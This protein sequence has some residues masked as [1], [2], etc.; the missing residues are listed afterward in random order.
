MLKEKTFKASKASINYAEGP[1]SGPPLILLHGLSGRWQS[2]L[3]I[4]QPLTLRWHVFALDLRGHGKSSH[5]GLY[6]FRDYADDIIEFARELTSE[7]AV[8]IGQSLGALIAFVVTSE[9]PESIRAVVDLDAEPNPS[10]EW[11]GKQSEAMRDLMI[12]RK[13]LAQNNRTVEDYI[14]ALADATRPGQDPPVRIGDTVDDIGL[15]IGAFYA[16]KLDPEVYTPFIDISKDWEEFFEDYDAQ[17]ILPKI[18]C[19]VLLIRGDPKFDSTPSD[20][21]I[22][23]AKSLMP[24]M[25]TATIEDK[26]HDLGRSTW[27]VAPLL[28]ALMTFLESVR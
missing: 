8:L 5:P 6:K 1:K 17:E 14:P 22:K 4:I 13:E 9:I 28:R 16:T 12:W 18:R 7:P 26:G 23:R 10:K 19:P 11:A 21:E 15:L 27:D 24:Q 3:P 2:F 25:I 20:E